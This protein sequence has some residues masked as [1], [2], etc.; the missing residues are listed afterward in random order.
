MNSKDQ[1]GNA[2]R[3]GKQGR[4]TNKAMIEKISE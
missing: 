4:K 2:K 3:A 1:P